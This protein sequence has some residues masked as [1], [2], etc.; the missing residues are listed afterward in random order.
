MNPNLKPVLPFDKN[1]LEILSEVKEHDNFILY[2]SNSRFLTNKSTQFTQHVESMAWVSLAIGEAKNRALADVPALSYATLEFFN[3]LF[4]IFSSEDPLLPTKLLMYLRSGH[5]RA[6]T[7]SH[8]TLLANNMEEL[9][10]LFPTVDL[11]PQ[12]IELMFLCP[13]NEVTLQDFYILYSCLGAIHHVGFRKHHIQFLFILTMNLA[14]QNHISASHI[15][16][17]RE[18]SEDFPEL[19]RDL[20][21]PIL[22]VAGG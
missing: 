14:Y 1:Q 2:I 20:E 9:T 10:Q 3:S 22:S 7:D 8:K 21:V 17:R 11:T 12:S 5:A 13:Q 19:G 15:N 16:R 4:P 18:L 6:F